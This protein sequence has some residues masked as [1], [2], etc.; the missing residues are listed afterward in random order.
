MTTGEKMN[1]YK[2]AV[3]RTHTNK[4]AQK[5]KTKSGRKKKTK[6]E[7]KANKKTKET[8]AKKKKETQTKTKKKKMRRR[9]TECRQET[10]RR[11][12]AYM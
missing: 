10:Y 3:E 6:K 12:T 2:K 8:Q 11:Y 4:K 1:Q 9:Y 7:K 5:K